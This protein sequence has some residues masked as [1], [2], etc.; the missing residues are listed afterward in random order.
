M[1]EV[2]EL[3]YW[4]SRAKAPVGIFTKES[5]RIFI[6][7]TYC[8]RL[9][10]LPQMWQT[11]LVPQ[12]CIILESNYFVTMAG[13]AFGSLSYRPLKSRNHLDD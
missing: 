7:H 9:W 4:D 11:N 10:H 2:E 12:S 5:Y 8:S 13:N 3:E 1:N 6:S